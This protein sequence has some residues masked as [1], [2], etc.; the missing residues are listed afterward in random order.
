MG[1]KFDSENFSVESFYGAIS[2]AMDAI[3][4]LVFTMRGKMYFTINYQ[5]TRHDEKRMKKISEKQLV[6]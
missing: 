5:K 3:T 4:L 6:L 1:V 2:F